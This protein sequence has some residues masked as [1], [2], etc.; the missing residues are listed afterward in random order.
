MTNPSIYAAIERLWQHVVALVGSK[1]NVVHSHDDLYYTEAEVDEMVSGL[2]TTDNAASK[3]AEAK[4]YAKTQASSAAGS[5][6]SGHNTDST[7]HSDIRDALAEAQDT[8]NAALLKTGGTMTG[9]L[10]AQNNTN[11]DT[12]QVRNIFLVADGE[13]LPSGSN[14]DICLVYTP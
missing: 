5:A 9:A 8:V 4:A 3:L 11:Y 13:A 7:A 10:V 14:G 12:K 1:A 2:E 6:V